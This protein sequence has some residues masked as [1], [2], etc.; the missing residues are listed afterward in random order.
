MTWTTDQARERD[1]FYCCKHGKKY[2]IFHSQ[3]E[4]EVPEMWLQDLFQAKKY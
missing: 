2:R 1:V 4:H 3:H